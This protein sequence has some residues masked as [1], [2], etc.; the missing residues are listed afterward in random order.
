MTRGLWLHKLQ[1][2]CDDMLHGRSLRDSWVVEPRVRP[3]VLQFAFFKL[4]IEACV[5]GK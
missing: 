3:V 2:P 4:Q 1:R 5:D